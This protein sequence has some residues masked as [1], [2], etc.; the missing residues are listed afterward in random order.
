MAVFFFNHPNNITCIR[1]CRQCSRNYFSCLTSIRDSVYFYITFVANSL[2]FAWHARHILCTLWRWDL[3]QS[4]YNYRDHI[5]NIVNTKS[6]IWQLCRYL[7]YRKLSLRQLTVPPVT[8]KSSSWRS[9][10]FSEVYYDLPNDLESLWTPSIFIERVFFIW[11]QDINIDF[12]ILR[13]MVKNIKWNH[14]IT[15]FRLCP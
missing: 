12:G 13:I 6:S 8:I 14:F 9:P 5:Y 2:H 15:T 11:V 3:F 1:V 10:V 7:W 4:E